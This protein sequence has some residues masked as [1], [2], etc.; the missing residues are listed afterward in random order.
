MKR[1]DFLIGAAASMVPAPAI[2]EVTTHTFPAVNVGVPGRLIMRGVL[3][4]KQANGGWLPIGGA[5]VKVG[6]SFTFDP[7]HAGDT[8]VVALEKRHDPDDSPFP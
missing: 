5:H 2:A 4:V 7:G 3:M 6:D 8:Q 1:R